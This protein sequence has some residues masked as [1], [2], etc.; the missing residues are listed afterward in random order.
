MLIIHARRFRTQEQ[1]RQDAI[2]RLAALIRKAA[3]PVKARHKTRP[4]A[5][6]REKRLESKRRQSKTKRMRGQA[7]Q[8][9]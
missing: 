7:P 5:A 1:N 9:E 4:T 8:D 6:S 2:E 3:Q